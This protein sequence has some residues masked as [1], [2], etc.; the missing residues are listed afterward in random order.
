MAGQSKFAWLAVAAFGLGIAGAGISTHAQV[1]R[2]RAERYFALG[3]TTSVPGSYKQA[4]EHLTEAIRLNP[5]MV[6]AYRL[7]AAAYGQL[8]DYKHQVSD[9]N[10][11]IEFDSNDA[12]AYNTR[13]W[14]RAILG[15]ELERAASD[16]NLALKF[17]PNNP[18]FLDSRGLV[19]LKQGRFQDAYNDYN[20]AILIGNRST[21]GFASHL[22]GRGIAQGKLG[23]WFGGESDILQAERI[24]PGIERAYSEYG[25]PR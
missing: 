9:A 22:Y 20:S 5:R 16:C 8:G 2:Q 25:V 18:N 13:C 11:L 14:A 17:Q 12:P 24:R 21:S 15:E 7:R 23:N 10:K 1:Q 19:R 3:A 4:I 6:K